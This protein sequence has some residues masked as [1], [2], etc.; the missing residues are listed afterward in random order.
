MTDLERLASALDSSDPEE[1][2]RAVAGLASES[3][4]EAL[5]LLLKALGDT[6]WRVRKE[7]TNAAVSRAPSPEVLS[8][9]VGAL[10]PGDNVGLR[11]ATVEALG[12]YG[13][14]AVSALER[15][16]CTLDAD[17]R[18]LAV[19]ALAKT[20]Q[21]SAIA[22][23]SDLM[24]DADP[25][26]RA[27]AVESIAEVG[28]AWP[29]DA[30]PLLERCLRGDDR[31]RAMV[32][33]D[34]L[35]RLGAV[36]PWEQL[37]AMLDDPVLRRPAVR[38]AGHSGDPRATVSLIARLETTRGSARQGLLESL[39]GSVRRGPSTSGA[40]R[41][42]LGKLSVAARTEL[43]TDAREAAGDALALRRAAL[44]LLG[45]LDD[46]QAIEVVLDA[47]TDDRVAAESDEACSTLGALAVPRMLE[48]ARSSGGDERAMWLD[49]IRRSVG[50][51]PAAAAVAE[52]RSM[53]SDDSPE[54]VRA[55]LAAL[56]VIGDDECL[57]AAARVLDAAESPLVRQAAALAVAHLAQ[58]H[59]ESARELARGASGRGDGAH[60][61]V[62]VIGALGASVRGGVEG[63]ARFLAEALASASTA[64]RCAALEALA[65]AGGGSG[66]ESVIFALSDE[67]AEV[68]LAA[69]R[70][71][72]R[73]RSDSGAAVGVDA[74][75]RVVAA[76]SDSAL[77][78]R[79]IA[80]LGASGDPRGFDVL[81]PVA[82]SGDPL[83]AVSA[84]EALAALV[85]P[86]RVD[87]LVDALQHPDGEVVKAALRALAVVSEPRV[88]AHL[89]VC[90]DHPAWDVRRLAA[91]LLGRIGG[92]V[93][94][95]LLR[96]K[97]GTE[98]EP[99]VR[100]AIHGAIAEIDAGTSR[101][102]PS[103]PPSDGSVRPK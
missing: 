101:R 48:R 1:R 60:A 25:N 7:A 28:V 76:S 45:L 84:V 90:L 21:A 3:R 95:G 64:V 88:V 74:L 71:L 81:R 19:E 67:E 18:K 66:I 96:A 44:V 85:G 61:A 103:T 29:D 69:V 43:L 77:V 87:A 93:A 80:A 2:R 89:G 24:E 42:A 35:N 13:A 99:S 26:V 38:A 39:V 27:T 98:H 94:G 16:L 91:D 59:P 9:L 54:V 53:L 70:A 47:L 83:L 63:T 52:I 97:L 50:S 22:A 55:A 34:G 78:A 20:G 56:A 37:E 14:A 11:N 75:L 86:Q 40:A 68:R 17:G 31:Y 72:G 32:A 36:L 8:V 92:P 82:R 49:A 79:A 73:V 51:S 6:D 58:R 46:D 10:G 23:L 30:I 12:S 100:D 102:P 15:A 41:L 4:R 57:H 62:I 5:P 65:T 33:L